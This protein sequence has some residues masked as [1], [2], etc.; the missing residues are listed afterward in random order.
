M[1]RA[2]VVFAAALCGCV[3]AISVPNDRH[4]IWWLRWVNTVS[5]GWIGFYRIY[6]SPGRRRR[7][8][9]ACAGG[10]LAV[11]SRMGVVSYG[12]G[13]AQCELA[14]AAFSPFNSIRRVRPA[15]VYKQVA[16]EH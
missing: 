10:L 4:L 15:A 12:Q 16:T 1:K 14:C 8:A 3:F 9:V 6:N 7:V 13:R 2:I 5:L 11:R